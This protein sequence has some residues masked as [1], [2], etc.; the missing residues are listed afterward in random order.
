MKKTVVSALLA[1]TLGFAAQ[2]AM[3]AQGGTITFN[4]KIVATTCQVKAGTENKTVTL[5]TVAQSAFSRVGDTAGTVGFLIELEQCNPGTNGEPTAVK[6]FFYANEKTNAE[7][8]VK[9]TASATSASVD[10]Q[11]LD[12]DGSTVIDINK[13]GAISGDTAQSSQFTALPATKIRYSVRYYATQASVSVGEVTGKV[14]YIL[15]YK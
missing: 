12:Q 6:A 9:N 8:R 4:G 3:A 2:S 5:P 1:T 11:L 14:D 7:G 13:D 15:A 10:L